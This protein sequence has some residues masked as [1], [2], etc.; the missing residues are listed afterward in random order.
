MKGGENVALTFREAGKIVQYLRK[1]G[2]SER[3]INDFFVVI[4]ET[5]FLPDVAPSEAEPSDSAEK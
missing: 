3:Q 4:G 1:A 5:K 2:L